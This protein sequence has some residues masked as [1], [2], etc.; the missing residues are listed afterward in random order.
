MD[1]GTGAA[2]AMKPLMNRPRHDT[3]ISVPTGRV[4]RDR[5]AG[6]ASRALDCGAGGTSRASAPVMLEALMRQPD[7]ERL[8]DR[9][10]LLR[11]HPAWED[12]LLHLPR[13]PQRGRSL[14]RL[15]FAVRP[16]GPPEE[17]CAVLGARFD[18]VLSGGTVPWC[19]PALLGLW[20]ALSA[21]PESAVAKNPDLVRLCRVDTGEGFGV[22]HDDHTRSPLGPRS[23]E[24]SIFRL[25]QISTE[26]RVPLNRFSATVRHEVGHAVAVRCG[27]YDTLY[28]RVPRSPWVFQGDRAAFL[29][30]L[31]KEEHGPEAHRLCELY[32]SQPAGKTRSLCRALDDLR[33]EERLAGRRPSSPALLREPALRDLAHNSRQAV[34]C[35]HRLRPTQEGLVYYY[36]SLYRRGFAYDVALHRATYVSD[37]QFRAP[38]E[39]FAELY[40]VYYADCDRG[41]PPGRSLRRLS[42]PLRE[43]VEWFDTRL[44]RRRSVKA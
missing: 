33:R 40:A 28:Q 19:W 43:I 27:L 42:R 3:P 12:F 20:R 38:N 10:R 21:L 1:A 16:E 2:P 25:D 6:G 29:R 14:E 17:G 8:T 5:G 4:S 44:D 22:Y 24:I 35:Y 11:E 18:L 32:L 39:W 36:D 15:F 37:Y 34:P 30:F 23:A 26:Y 13:G 9:V 7:E 41:R 31:L